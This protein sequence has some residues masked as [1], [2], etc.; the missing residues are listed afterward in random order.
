[1]DLVSACLAGLPCRYDGRSLPDPSVVQAVREGRAVPACAEQLAGLDTP[2]AAAE[3][4][5]GDGHDVLAGRAR[6]LTADGEDVTTDYVRGAELVA[7]L[8]VRHGLNTAVLQARS[9][10]CGCGSVYDGTHSGV[11]VAGDGVVTAVLRQ[12]GLQVR[13]VRGQRPPT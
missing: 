5:G 6:V 7:D 13:S 1:M 4:V 11:L 9:P 3:L 12:R 2:R 10:S 8:A